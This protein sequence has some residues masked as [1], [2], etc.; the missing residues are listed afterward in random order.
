MAGYK[1]QGTAREVADGPLT[2]NGLFDPSKCGMYP[3]YRQHYRY[4][5][6]MCDKCRKAYNDYERERE[7][8]KRARKVPA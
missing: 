3:N 5:V 4:K 7:A 2:P 1:W 6:P 8:R